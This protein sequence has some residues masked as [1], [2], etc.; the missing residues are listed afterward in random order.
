[1][2]CQHWNSELIF[3]L[4][5][6][7]YSIESFCRFSLVNWKYV[8]DIAAMFRHGGAVTNI[9]TFIVCFWRLCSNGCL[10]YFLNIFLISLG[11]T[12][13]NNSCD[14]FLQIEQSPPEVHAN[15]AETL[16]AITRN[17]SSTLAVKLSSP[18]FVVF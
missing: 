14:C 3:K 8:F 12:S 15:A 2:Q 11:F 6:C 5:F 17:A 9:V 18:R 4:I 16:C 1:M 10:V 13:C 7:T